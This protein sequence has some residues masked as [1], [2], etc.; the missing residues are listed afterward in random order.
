MP[1]NA[2]IVDLRNIVRFLGA[3]FLSYF[4]FGVF[5]KKAQILWSIFANRYF[6]EGVLRVVYLIKSF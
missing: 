4:A 6:C 2:T 3:V 5:T 1:K